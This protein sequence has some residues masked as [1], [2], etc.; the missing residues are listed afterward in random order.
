MSKVYAGLLVGI[1]LIAM[2]AIGTQALTA[3]TDVG[4]I[5]YRVLKG[6][7]VVRGA[8]SPNSKWRDD[9]CDPMGDSFA[10]VV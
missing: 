6:R 5:A 7:P 1:A 8:I 3:V 4:S 9:N 10:P 2:A